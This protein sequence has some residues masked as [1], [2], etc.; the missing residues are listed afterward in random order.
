MVLVWEVEMGELAVGV[1]V[2]T[3]EAIESEVLRTLVYVDG[4][5]AVIVGKHSMQTDTD[6]DGAN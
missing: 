2:L 1:V 5:G 3:S 6:E 4:R